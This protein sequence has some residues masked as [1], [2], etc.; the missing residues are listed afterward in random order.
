MTQITF[1]TLGKFGKGIFRR[2]SSTNAA[3]E[4][5]NH[6]VVVENADSG[7]EIDE[8][9]VTANTQVRIRALELVR[10]WE[11]NQE[12]PSL[13]LEKDDYE[14]D[15]VRRQTHFEKSVQRFDKTVAEHGA[16]LESGCREAVREL[17]ELI[18]KY[19]QARCAG[20]DA[21]TKAHGLLATVKISAAGNFAGSR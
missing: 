7:L 9:A 5:Q 17:R 1:M 19:A 11:A 14:T 21:V 20:S 13:R 16:H 12:T 2:G 4:D 8:A 10:A 6:P 15:M 3:D 18:G